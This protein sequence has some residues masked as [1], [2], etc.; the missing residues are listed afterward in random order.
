MKV[1]TIR[2]KRF[3]TVSDEAS[4]MGIMV[5]ICSAHGFYNTE[6]VYESKLRLQKFYFVDSQTSK[7]TFIKLILI[8]GQHEVS[9]HYLFGCIMCVLYP[10]SWRRRGHVSSRLLSRTSY[11]RE[12]LMCLTEH[13]MD[14]RCFQ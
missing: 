2:T 5:L 12:L 9:F 13:N 8:F 1:D 4:L 14:V 3:Y 6:H 10:G 7:W 11:T